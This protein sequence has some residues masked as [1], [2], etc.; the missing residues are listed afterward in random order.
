MAADDEQV[1][2]LKRWWQKNWQSLVLGI[3]LAVLLVAGWQYWQNKQAADRAAASQ[4]FDTV[5][6]AL[7]SPDAEERMATME[8]ALDEL[9]QN[10]S[11]SPYAVFAAMV[12]ASVY[13][14]EGSPEKAADELSWALER[15]GD[16]PLPRVIRLRLA[17]AYHTAGDHESAL[18][19]L[20]GGPGKG[21]FEPLYRE[22]EGD[23][24]LAQGNEE[25]ALRAYRQARD[26]LEEGVSDRLLE[27]KL[28]ELSASEDG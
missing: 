18:A 10:Y 14:E 9:K 6:T 15:A 2:A 19:T 20:E 8:F 13:M 16:E 5:I 22:L 24:H 25:A 4:A 3:A 27:L 12:A 17:R 1:E 28:A 23:I 26:A 11:R 21:R 7:S